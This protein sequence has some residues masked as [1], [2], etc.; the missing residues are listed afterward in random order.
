M[1]R[2]ITCNVFVAWG[3][4]L[5]VV[6]AQPPNTDIG[7]TDIGGIKVGH[8]TLTERPTGCTV[9]LTEAGA[10]ATVDIRGSS[11]GTRETALLE[12]TNTVQHV[13]GIVLAGGSA[14]G[15]AAADGVMRYLEER[16]IGYETPAAKVPIVPAAILYDL[17]IGD[18]PSVRP[19]ADCGYRAAQ[20]ASDDPVIEGSVGAGSGATVGKLGGP[21]RA[22]K[23]GLGT[24]AVELP[25]GVL[26][27][28]LMAVNAVGDILDPDTGAII[29]GVRTPD[30]LGFAN[31]H[32]M[33]QEF[34]TEQPPHVN[35]TIGVVATNASLNKTQLALVAR[36][37]HDGLARAVR[38]SH[39]PS[40]GDAIFA[41]ATGQIRN[42][43]SL[44]QI[45]SAAANVTADAI[46][47]GVRAATS[48]PGYPSVRDFQGGVR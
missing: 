47:R 11:P 13:H 3:F 43:I 18:D 36:M 42:S 9:V 25:G 31:A 14:F 46:V 7:L 38:P 30:G 2:V 28:A 10:V 44:L 48:L 41:I 45:G 19:T 15:L 39:T 6:S 33:L 16:D 37:A 12:P 23:G 8:H 29:A 32:K 40:D 24:T 35:T 5:S 20:N 1:A 21:Q 27:A 22:M 26:V 17:G 34:N 4:A